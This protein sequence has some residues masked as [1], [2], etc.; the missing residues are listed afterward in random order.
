[1]V[2]IFINNKQFEVPSNFTVLQACEVAGI[3]IPRFCYH[4]K[5]SIAGNC[6]M[7][8]VQ[9]E[10]SL[11]PVASCAV[12]VLEGMSIFTDSSVVRKAREGVMEFL[13][14]NHPLDCP[15]CDQGGECDL[16]DQALLFGNDRGR[17]YE[18]KRSVSDKD[19]GPL[20][21]TI[22]TRCIHCTRCVRFS[23]ELSGRKELGTTGRGSRTE[24]GNYTSSFLLSELSGNIIDLCPVGALTSKPYAFTA[25]SWELRRVE[26]IDTLDSLGSNISFQVAGRKVA[27]I[28]PLLHEGL[29][30]EWVDDKT[31][32]SYDGFYLQ[33]LVQPLVLGIQGTYSKVSWEEILSSL[34]FFLQPSS[35][36]TLFVAGNSEPLES[37]YTLKSLKDRSLRFGFVYQDLYLPINIDFKSN[38][39][40]ADSLTYISDAGACLFIG[41]DFKK[42]QPLLLMRLRREQ[43]RRSLP[44]GYF[45]SPNNYGL[46]CFNLGNTIQDIFQFIEG[47]SF[48][49]SILKRSSKPLVI[50]GPS[51]VSHPAFSLVQQSLYNLNFIKR[52]KHKVVNILH[53]GS[54][55]VGGFE[56]GLS[57]CP[58][59]SDQV[60]S[61]GVDGL[62]ITKERVHIGTHGSDL[63]RESSLILPS[64]SAIESNSLYMNAEG[65]VQESKR[66]VSAFGDCRES[67]RL[68]DMVE[69]LTFQKSSVVNNKTKVRKSLFNLT[70]LSFNT[71]GY[72]N[73]SVASK[74]Y[75]GYF[76][77]SLV[78]NS[79]ESFYRGDP[80]TKSSKVMA[81]CVSQLDG[82]KPRSYKV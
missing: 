29:N 64:M 63:V 56:L 39:T 82:L 61:L 62:Q 76:Y 11:K 30:E 54:G 36:N 35:V 45:G 37:L 13:L 21:K 22:M 20:V 34:A 8:L 70:N 73:F 5:L 81:S 69:L 53:R 42:E 58:V 14:S 40:F 28:L 59:V 66:V 32:F 44:V 25:R 9:V 18:V 50:L 17:F 49:C 3:Q 74:N 75:K 10:K 60:L 79:N 19:C 52:A 67:Y 33:R 46:E 2:K 23:T 1:M 12:N 47:K 26:S 80:V 24:I 55:K 38:Y 71:L 72:E 57:P 31:R 7:C 51:L 41:V 77:N 43:A 6:R 48:F 27:R 4:E 16:Q 78:G 15:I 68:L 65:R